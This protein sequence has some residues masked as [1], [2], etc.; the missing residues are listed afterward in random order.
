MSVN[1]HSALD[2]V[3]ENFLSVGGSCDTSIHQA[4]GV[5]ASRI[6]GTLTERNISTRKA[7][8]MTGFA[9]A[10]FSRVRSAAYRRF[11]LDRLIR[12][13]GAL[14]HSLEVCV[15]VQPR[16]GAQKPNSQR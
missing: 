16:D 5:V 4:K 1:K 9:A 14:D 8:E 11:T 6:I 12:M 7:G 2:Q 13:L 10:D 3:K 15:T